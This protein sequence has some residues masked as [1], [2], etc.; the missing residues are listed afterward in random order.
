MGSGDRE[1]ESGGGDP[2]T[3]PAG[4]VAIIS[5]SVPS[6]VP[7]SGCRN[8]LQSREDYRSAL[9]FSE[10]PRRLLETTYRRLGDDESR[11]ELLNLLSC[12]RTQHAGVVDF[13]NALA[14]AHEIVD[15][16]KPTGVIA[17]ARAFRDLGIAFCSPGTAK[18][19]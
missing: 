18:R 8:C 5:W 11:T 7:R 9:M 14:A 19:A 13:Q 16:K 3:T 12:L 15:I 1:T 10:K 4:K 2:R 6:R 17:R